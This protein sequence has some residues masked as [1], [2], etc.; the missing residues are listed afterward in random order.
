MKHLLAGDDG[1]VAAQDRRR[2]RATLRLSRPIARSFPSRRPEPLRD[3]DRRIFEDLSKSFGELL[4]DELYARGGGHSFI[5]MAG[6]LLDSLDGPLPPLERLLLAYHIFDSCPLEVAG[7]Y[8]A[9]RYP[10]APE[11]HS[12]SGQGVGAGFTALRILQAPSRA[13]PEK[14]AVLVID[15]TTLPFRDRDLHSDPIIDAAV[16]L[17]SGDADAMLELESLTEGIALDPGTALRAHAAQDPDLLIIM[18]RELCKRLRPLSNGDFGTQ[19]VAGAADQLC[20]SAW[21][22]LADHWDPDRRIL[23][24]DFDPCA[25][26]LFE[27]WLRPV[28]CW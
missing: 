2:D 21:A 8:I 16:L 19:F 24:A 15:Q 20:T 5:D 25:E 14:G 13:A 1:A 17:T 23:V 9:N 28:S 26:R 18:G 3:L 6:E 27:A 22:A 10:G 11:V 4:D 12:V 7:C